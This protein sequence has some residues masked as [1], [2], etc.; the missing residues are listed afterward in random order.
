MT[1]LPS[2]Y[3]IESFS[4][5]NLACPFCL[6]GIAKRAPNYKESSLDMELFRQIV[7][8]DLGGSHF[9]EL[10][11]RGEPTLHRHLGEMVRL[12][13][14]KVMVGF[15]THGNTL[16][17]RDNLQAALDC[18]YLTISV[19]AGTKEG[20]EA[21]RV[22]GQWEKMLG[23]ID[24]LFERR[25]ARLYPHIDLQ[26]IEED[27][28][29]FRWQDELVALKELIKKREWGRHVLR[30]IPNS[31][32]SWMNPNFVSTTT[33]LCLNPW[34]SVSIKVNGDVVP[35]CMS[36][37]DEPEMVYGNLREQ[38]LEQIWN[39]KRV[40]NFRKI[41]LDAAMND[42]RF[43]PRTC[44]TCHNRS[45]ALYHDRILVDSIRKG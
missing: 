4:R 5:C 41:H 9:I 40:E 15:S 19:D 11:F 39:S 32:I 31:S 1:R 16:H 45:P 23:N 44:Q 20:Y 21:K 34:M 14:D 27:V 17:V 42:P 29:G 22:G 3:Q 6:T 43:L 38:S 30:T 28:G 7:D 10:Q 35:C 18:H 24:I 2:I 33:E 25:G 26:L 37:E 12:L 8:R 36:F 13:K